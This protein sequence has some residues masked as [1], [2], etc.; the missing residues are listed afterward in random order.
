VQDHDPFAN[1]RAVKHSGNAFGP[2][3][4]EFKQAIAHRLGVWLPKIWTHRP[5]ATCQDD[6]ACSKGVWQR[7]DVLLDTL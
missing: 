6:I 3:E 2:F 1:L 4:S 5:H 7:Q